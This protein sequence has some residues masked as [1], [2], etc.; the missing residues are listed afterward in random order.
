MEIVRR[1]P[2]AAP[3]ADLLYRT[4]RLT[5]QAAVEALSSQSECEVLRRDSDGEY[6]ALF[7]N[8]WRMD[9][10]CKKFPDLRFEA[11]PAG[12]SVS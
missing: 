8:K 10:I 1:M 3:N 7:S 9:I 2:R 5:E 6:L 12:S 4:A 11:M